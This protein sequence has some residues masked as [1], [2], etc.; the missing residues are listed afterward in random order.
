[1]R[2][3]RPRS[4][5]GLAVAIIAAV[6][7]LLPLLYVFSMGPVVWLVS[8]GYADGGPGSTVNNIYKPLE[9]ACVFRPFRVFLTYYIEL[10]RS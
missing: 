2:E 9:Q 5:S 10:W 8:R 1:M 6:F 7:F 3:H 4:K